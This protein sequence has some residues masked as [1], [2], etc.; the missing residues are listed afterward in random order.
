M[1]DQQP[2]QPDPV[3]VRNNPESRAG[4]AEGLQRVARASDGGAPPREAPPQGEMP[5]DVR[6]G[7]SEGNPI[8]GVTI[9][10]EDRDKAVSADD[11]ATG[12]LTAGHA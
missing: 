6:G 10:P 12:G 4:A 3:D 7:T 8:A 2:D 9:D 5:E 11:T 1:S